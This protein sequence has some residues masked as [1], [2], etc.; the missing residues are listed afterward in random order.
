MTHINALLLFDEILINKLKK[1][2]DIV[3]LHKILDQ[4]LTVNQMT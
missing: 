2:G 4:T 1:T 3:Y